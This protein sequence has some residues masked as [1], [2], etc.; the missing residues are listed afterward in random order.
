M[1]VVNYA[2]AHGHYPPPFV[3]G[4]DGRPWHSWRVLILPHIEGQAIFDRY[5]FDEPW[6][7]PNNRQL[8]GAM[9]KMYAF[10]GTNCTGTTITNYVAVV[11]KNTMWPPD[12]KR[13]R[14]EITDPSNT[15]LIAENRGRNVPWM[16]PRDLDFDTMNFA[17]NHPDGLSSWHD[18]P[19]AVTADGGVRGVHTGYTPESLRAMLTFTR[20]PRFL[21]PAVQ[22]LDDGRL[23]PIVEPERGGRR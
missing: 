5:K 19:A 12:G 4:P 20:K 7:G 1:A 9:P 22:P 13:T 16:E 10:H 2:E 21:D 6:D 18:Y 14:W 15:I 17:F 3:R 8:A 11:G 23:R